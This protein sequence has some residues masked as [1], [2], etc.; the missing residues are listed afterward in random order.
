MT[1]V[2][3]VTW[4][5]L[6]PK[7]PLLR[8]S[9]PGTLPF[10]EDLQIDV[11][12]PVT[13]LIGENGSGKS[14]LLEAIAVLA[15]LP[16]SGGS[17]NELDEGFAY[18]EE[19][20]LANSMNLAFI[21]HPRD[22]YFF[23]AENQTYF[24]SL[25][26]SRKYDPD[27]WGDPYGRYGGKSLHLMSH[28]EAF[29]AIMQHRFDEGLYLMDEP[30]SALSP[31]RQLSL[32][33]LLY[34]LV[35]NRHCQFIIATHSPILLTYPEATILTFDYGKIQS[36]EL[37]ETSHFQITSGILKNPEQYWRHLRSQ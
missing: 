30:E 22:R 33:A 24:A 8:D 21:E 7:R 9:F 12:S 25:L 36:I 5:G 17:M 1:N 14:T 6:N 10:T 37:E 27:F 31:K 32:L 16:I 2:P 4:I 35:E 26:D 13:F 19:S 3:Y 15:K 18:S 34:D 23:R 28:G 20:L 11:K 29:L